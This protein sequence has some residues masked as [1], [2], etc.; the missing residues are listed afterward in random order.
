M[1]LFKLMPA[2]LLLFAST[3]NAF[4]QPAILHPELTT[5]TARATS[6]L[7]G[8]AYS[9]EDK[10][11]LK[12]IFTSIHNDLVAQI[13][14]EAAEAAIA[15]GEYLRGDLAAV[16][17]MKL[18]RSTVVSS[19]VSSEDLWY[20]FLLLKMRRMTQQIMGEASPHFLTADN[21]AYKKLREIM[22]E[23]KTR[24]LSLPGV[25]IKKSMNIE[26]L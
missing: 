23:F 25:N 4:A 26:R 6:E 8:T 5:W 17:L 11:G 12:A 16:S 3:G 1:N 18:T 2:G 7:P 13:E 24:N 15:S 22:L 21:I 19:D 14:A 9:D 10:T 20:S